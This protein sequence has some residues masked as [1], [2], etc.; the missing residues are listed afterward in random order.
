MNLA[1]DMLSVVKAVR[2]EC[3]ERYKTCFCDLL[4]SCYK[5]KSLSLLLYIQNQLIEQNLRFL[6]YPL[7][8][9]VIK[10]PAYFPR[11][12]DNI[13]NRYRVFSDPPGILG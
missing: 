9:S 13:F 8:F 2:H 12:T 3:L 11:R 5:M 7:K 10:N 1:Q 4:S 6:S